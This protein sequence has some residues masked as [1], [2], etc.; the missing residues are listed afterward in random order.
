MR[1]FHASF[2]LMV[3]KFGI[4]CHLSFMRAPHAY[5]YLLYI[6]TS[7]HVIVSRKMPMEESNVWVPALQCPTEK[8]VSAAPPKNF[9]PHNVRFLAN[10]LLTIFNELASTFLNGKPIFS[11][12]TFYASN[13]HFVTSLPQ[14]DLFLK[15]FF[16]QAIYRSTSHRKHECPKFGQ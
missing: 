2:E 10:M 7:Y 14:V 13:S 5:I 11:T 9:L 16:R 12:S 4:V 3:N 15:C 6:Y 1:A 8:K